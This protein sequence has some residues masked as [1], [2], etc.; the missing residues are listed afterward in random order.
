M[1][2]N[3]GIGIAANQIGRTERFIIVM[4]GRKGLV[5]MINPVIVSASDA[6]NIAD[7]G[8]LS[9]PGKIVKKARSTYLEVE[10]LDLKGDKQYLSL[11]HLNARITAH[12]IDHL[13]GITFE[14]T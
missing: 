3:N 14:G 10:Y 1:L 8:C 4:L 13:N 6:K 5:P 2:K 9:Y 11:S 12:E 7:E